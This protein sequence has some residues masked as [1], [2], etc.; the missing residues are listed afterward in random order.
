MSEERMVTK[1]I[2]LDIDEG[3]LLCLGHG[4]EALGTEKDSAS[5]TE[6]SEGGR[7]KKII[8]LDIDERCLL[9]LRHGEEASETE[10]LSR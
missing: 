10:D 3:H 7:V 1:I 2:A 6:M 8:A 4:E 9:R 5:K